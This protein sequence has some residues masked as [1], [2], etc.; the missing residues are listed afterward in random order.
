MAVLYKESKDEKDFRDEK[1]EDRIPD[2]ANSPLSI[3]HYQLS[4]HLALW[5][6]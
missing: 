6:T 2:I 1:D 5:I 4:I 3:I